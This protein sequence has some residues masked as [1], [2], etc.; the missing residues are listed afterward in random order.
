MVKWLFITS[1]CV[2]ITKQ[3]VSSIVV[4]LT[5]SEILIKRFWLFHYLSSTKYVNYVNMFLRSILTDTDFS[6]SLEI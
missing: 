2:V 1:Y 4:N 3:Y 5:I 6:L